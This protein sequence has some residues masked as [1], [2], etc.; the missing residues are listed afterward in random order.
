MVPVKHRTI[1]PLFQWTDK[2][3]KEWPLTGV[4]LT[5]HFHSLSDPPVPTTLRVSIVYEYIIKLFN[6]MNSPFSQ[7]QML[8]YL[9]TID[10]LPTLE[11]PRSTSR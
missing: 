9:A 3:T 1:L 11:E 4:F 5:S 7:W 2:R 8:Q 6:I 10:V